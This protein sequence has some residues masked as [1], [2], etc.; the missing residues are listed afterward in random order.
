MV[1][2]FE[3]R[4][5]CVKR[6]WFLELLVPRLIDDFRDEVLAGSIGRFLDRT[7]IYLG[8]IFYLGSVNFSS[9]CVLIN[10]VVVECNE[11]QD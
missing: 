2:K 9:R 7:V 4:D 10:C 3:G 8:F 11:W 6:I 5:V 1:N